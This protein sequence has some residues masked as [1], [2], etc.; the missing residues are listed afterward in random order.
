[1]HDVMHPTHMKPNLTGVASLNEPATSEFGSREVKT[2]SIY[3]HETK[4]HRCC[5]VIRSL[6][7]P[8]TSEFG[9]REH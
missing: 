2:W 9:S 3:K 5:R 8:A 7:E 1:M 4:S 6:N